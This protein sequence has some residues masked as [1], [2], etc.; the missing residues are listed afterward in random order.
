MGHSFSQPYFTKK[1]AEQDLED[2]RYD[3][4]PIDDINML[5]SVIAENE[6]LRGLNVTIPYKVEVLQ[7]CDE[8]DAEAAEIGAVNTLLL[9]KSGAMK[10]YNTD[11]PGFRDSLR[12]FLKETTDLNALVLGTGGASKAVRFVLSQMDIPFQ[13]VSRQASEDAISYE[14]LQGLHLQDFALI[15][16]TTPLGM[17]PHLDHRPDLRYDQLGEHHYLYDLIYNPEVTSFLQKGLN[18]GA[19]TKNGSEMLM[20]Q[21]EASWSIWNQ[22]DE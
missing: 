7:F 11:I 13:S 19:Q 12:H 4:Y 5:P 2:C 10:G 8:L 20:L 22:E 6:Q 16:N 21:A 18:L 14:Q 17:A 15:I 9:K 1:F 3:N